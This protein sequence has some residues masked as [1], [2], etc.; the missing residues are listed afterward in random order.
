MWDHDIL[1]QVKGI[2]ANIKSEIT[3]AVETNPS[4]EYAANLEEFA[5]D[6]ASCSPRIKIVKSEVDKPLARFSILKDGYPTGISF[7]K[8]QK[9]SPI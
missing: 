5:E 3:L 6:I 2:F 7:R 1:E 9:E 4:V 8:K